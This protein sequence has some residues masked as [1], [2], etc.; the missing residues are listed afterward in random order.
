[1]GWFP[2]DPGL[3]D[4]PSLGDVDGSES[5]RGKNPLLGF[6]TATGHPGVVDTAASAGPDFICI[7]TQHGVPLSALDQS[8]FTV[9]AH[10]EAAGLVRVESIDSAPIGRALDLGA[11]GVVI[12]LVE[13]ADDAQH[14][15]AACRYA[16]RGNRSYG[17]Q[18]RR[19]SP[20]GGSP[21]VCWIQ[22][23]TQGAM[24]HLKEIAAIEG[25]DALYIGPADLGLA[26]VGQPASDV[27]AV[28]DGSHPHAAEMRSAFEM[29][30]EACEEAG[31][32]AGLHCGSGAAAA[33]AIEHGFQIAAV[34]ADLAFVR[35]KLSDELEV[36]R[37]LSD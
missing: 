20:L 28:F 2:L 26:L 19:V 37:S 11:D 16:P 9:I 34:G 1:M 15:V 22:V 10:Y 31:I 24:S 5:L 12:P 13:S 7:D 23:E 18:T 3:V 29:V 27:E 17:V 30:V 32:R 6:W 14:A 8:T 36:A 35:S 33:T 21:P 25:V 4:L